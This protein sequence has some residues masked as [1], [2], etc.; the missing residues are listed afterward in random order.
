MSVVKILGT[1][2]TQPNRWWVGNDLSWDAEVPLTSVL[3]IQTRAL[4]QG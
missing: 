2:R 1:S 4:K 3:H